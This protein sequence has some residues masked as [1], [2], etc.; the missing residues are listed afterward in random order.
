MNPLRWRK[1]TW[2]IV[3]FTVLMGAWIIAGIAV[4]NDNCDDEVV[5][6]AARS[7]CEAGTDIGTGIGVTALFCVWLIGFTILGVIWIVT[8]PARRVCPSCGHEARKGER[9]CRNCGFDFA[10]GS[11][12]AASQ[13][14]AAPVAAR[15]PLSEPTWVTTQS[16][17]AIPEPS[18]GPICPACGRQ[19]HLGD[20]V[21]ANC[22]TRLT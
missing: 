19:A 8:R 12:P 16:Q 18:P 6:S 17:G 3:A 7:A 10:T 4:N 21:C 9:V 5:G 15:A 2:A 22:G 20:R 11:H 14:Q 13:F 1:M